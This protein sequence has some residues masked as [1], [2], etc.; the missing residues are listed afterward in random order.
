MNFKNKANFGGL[1]SRER[2]DLI[3][4][5]KCF[6][7]VLRRTDSKKVKIEADRSYYKSLGERGL[8]KEYTH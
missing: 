4:I 5:L 7:L 2:D 3:C 6:F 1:K 8:R